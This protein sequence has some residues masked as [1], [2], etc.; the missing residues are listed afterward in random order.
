MYSD[1]HGACSSA[2]LFVRTGL[3]CDVMNISVYLRACAMPE[4]HLAVCDGH[5]VAFVV[6]CHDVFQGYF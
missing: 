1:F 3:C 2:A 4:R 6:R 5:D